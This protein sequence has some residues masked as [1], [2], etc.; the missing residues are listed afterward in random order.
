MY[1]QIA[2]GKN[3]EMKICEVCGQEHDGSFGSGR[4]CSRSC[5]NKRSHTQETKQKIKSSINEYNSRCVFTC[6]FCHAKFPSEDKKAEHE[7]NCS[8]EKLSRSQIYEN[9][10]VLISNG[11][12][13]DITRGELEKYRSEHQACEICG[14]TVDEIV[15][16]T[17]KFGP[18]SLCIDHE[19]STNRFR[20]LL[21]SVCN[22][23]L[24]WYEKNK[25]A[26][27]KY[28]NKEGS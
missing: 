11:V 13:I 15:K 4:F 2:V 12:Y 20:G 28:L 19:H 5:A 21:C 6:S 1:I 14:R 24:G 18:H 27:E 7:K 25:E 3:K 16:T 23:Q 9:K 8:R 22:R 26:I 17:S 10:P